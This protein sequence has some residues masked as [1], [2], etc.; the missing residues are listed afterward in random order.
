MLW[1][2]GWDEAP[3][4]CKLCLES[5]V[6]Y[7]PDWKVHKL[8][9]TN[10]LNY[11]PK[12]KFD[13]IMKVESWTHRSDLVRIYLLANYGGLWV[14]ATNFCNKPLKSWLKPTL[15]VNDCWFVMDENQNILTINFMYADKKIG[16]ASC[17]ERV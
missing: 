7:N 2:Q 11:V 3:P 5:W 13:K 6:H 15:F 9:L 10:I 4:V 12:E 16:R 17:R 1:F 8:S 14:D